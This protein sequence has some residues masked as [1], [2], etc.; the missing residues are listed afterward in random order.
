MVLIGLGH[1]QPQAEQTLLVLCRVR[2]SD[3]RFV[4]DAWTPL[5]A[6]SS[7]FLAPARIPVIE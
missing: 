7:S 4:D 2:R 6:S 3:Q 5:A 1:Q